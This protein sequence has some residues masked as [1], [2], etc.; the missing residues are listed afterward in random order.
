MPACTALDYAVRQVSLLQTP[1]QPGEKARRNQFP[2]ESHAQ[3]FRARP[4]TFLAGVGEGVVTYIEGL[5][6]YHNCDWPRRLAELSN[7]DKHNELLGLMQAFSI[8]FDD[9]EVKSAGKQ[10]GRKTVVWAEFDAMLRIGYRNPSRRDLMSELHEIEG[11]VSHT[12]AVFDVELFNPK[13]AKYPG[14]RFAGEF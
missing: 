12:L 6:P 5:Q 8:R 1:R 9:S 3:R 7:L 4:R 13:P 10:D 11:G 2:I 14:I